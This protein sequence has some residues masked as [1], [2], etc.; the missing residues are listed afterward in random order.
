MGNISFLEYAVNIWQDKNTEK[1]CIELQDNYKIN[2]VSLLW[3]CWNEYNG[4]KIDS[5]T[6][7]SVIKYAE[8]FEQEKILAIRKK[9]KENKDKEQYQDILNQ[10]I[11]QEIILIKKITDNFATNNSGTEVLDAISIFENIKNLKIDRTIIK[12]PNA[13]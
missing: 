5:N 13:T 10:E 11:E 12:L 9:R 4:V 6:I 1:Y 2:I 7:K 8:N 3:C